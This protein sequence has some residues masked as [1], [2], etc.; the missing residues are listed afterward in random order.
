MIQFA[1]CAQQFRGAAGRLGRWLL[2]SSVVVV[3]VPSWAQTPALGSP[4]L[5]GRVAEAD[6]AREALPG[7]SVFWLGTRQGT[8]ADAA[9]R[10]SIAYPATPPPWRLVVRFLGLRPD[11]LLLTD[12][13]PNPVAIGLRAPAALGEARVVGQREG[14]SATSVGQLETISTRDLTKSA[15]CN[16][17]ESFET[18]AAVE[19][20]TTDAVS[21]AKQIQLLGLDGAYSL[22]TVDNQ[23]ALRGLATPYRLNYLAG[24]W[25]EAIDIIKGTG[26]VVN[27]YE[28]ISGQVNVRLKEPDKAERLHLNVYANDL[29][30]TDYNV[31]AAAPLTARTSAEILLHAD[32]LGHRADRN[33]DGFLDLPL[34]TQYN[35]LAKWKYK[36]GTQWMVELGGGA[37]REVRRAGQTAFGRTDNP[38]T[39]AAY[40]VTSATDRLT[41]FGRASY[42][43]AGRPY[44]TIGVLANVTGHEVA[45]VYGRRPYD[46]RQ[47]TFQATALMQGIIGT[48]AHVWKAGVSFLHDDV[49][50]TLNARRPRARRERVPGGFAEYTYQ[51][52]HRL[53]AVA[54]L[55]F[56]HHNLYGPVLTPRLSVKYDFTP[57]TVLRLS[58]GTGFR[59]AN[60]VAEN[61]YALTS[62]RAIIFLDSV[63]QPE[64]ARNVGGSLTRYFAWHGRA[65]ALILDYYHTAFAQQVVADMYADPTALSF[66]NLRGSSTAQSVQTEVHYEVVKGLEVKAAW[67]WYDV[68]SAYTGGYELP[69]A[70]LPRHRAF[71]NLAYASA[72]DKW[73]FDL[74]VQWYGQRPLPGLDH[75]H[76]HAGIAEPAPPPPMRTTPRYAVLNAQVT[77]AFK[78]LEVYAGVENL[79]DYRQPEAIVAAD[80]PFSSRF[81]AGMV[82]GPIFGRLTYAGLR[83]TLR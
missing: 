17:A 46:G 58:A 49:R 62:S 48:T 74:T 57:E 50:E 31:V 75:A 23:P 16:L 82:W 71:L 18:N 6:G 30:K 43:F 54:G 10:F 9:G 5:T 36:D 72:F 29:G 42:T 32:Y 63:L 76:D 13:A 59:V 52:S 67:K 64:R 11:T 44:Q 68:R 83:Y 34:A 33:H 19:V 79:T 51:D 7:A 69:R 78:Q 3:A 27:G 39:S 47:T 41:A 28:G 38:F 65:G 53:T 14:H 40:G 25:I 2:L 56:D 35:G 12:R 1:A 26:S 8:A 22:L 81:D 45:A 55:R 37:L 80:S 60:P 70:L 77:R 15:C 61:S 21:G 20:S 66:S 4:P 24:P 73:R